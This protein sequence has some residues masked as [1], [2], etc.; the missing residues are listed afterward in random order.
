MH[1]PSP[2]FKHTR[3]HF[4]LSAERSVLSNGFQ[5][6]YLRTYLRLFKSWL[7]R[8]LNIRKLISCQ[9]ARPAVTR[10]AGLKRMGV[11][12]PLGAFSDHFI[13]GCFRFVF[14]TVQL[15]TLNSWAFVSRWAVFTPGV[16]Q[17]ATIIGSLFPRECKTTLSTCGCTFERCFFLSFWLI[18]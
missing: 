13:V 18:V 3:A 14:N 7:L 6:D 4:G 1:Y 2:M 5:I 10:P 17:N 15:L 16:I 11:Q 12:F 8:G 9:L